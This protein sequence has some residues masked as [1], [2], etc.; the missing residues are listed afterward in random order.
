MLRNQE[1]DKE[2]K[3]ERE[4]REAERQRRQ[5]AAEAERIWED[6]MRAFWSVFFMNWWYYPLAY[7]LVLFVV[8]NMATDGDRDGLCAH[9]EAERREKERLEEERERERL[10]KQNRGCCICSCSM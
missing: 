6:K 1:F 3:R 9:Y 8:F 4:A 2:F 10:E 5:E 7:L